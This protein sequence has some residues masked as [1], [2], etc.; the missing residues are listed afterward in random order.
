MLKSISSKHNIN[1]MRNVIVLIKSRYLFATRRE[2]KFAKKSKSLKK[3]NL[4]NFN[5]VSFG[6]GESCEIKISDGK[7]AGEPK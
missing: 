6:G 1:N 4:I 7:L 3:I 2:T 5:R